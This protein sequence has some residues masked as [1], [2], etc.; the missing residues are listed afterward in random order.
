MKTD[1]IMFGDA[2][3]S[4]FG[5][6]RPISLESGLKFDKQ[7]FFFFSTTSFGQS[8]TLPYSSQP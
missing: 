8:E 2:V 4:F 5:T 1:R 6:F 7:A 3:M